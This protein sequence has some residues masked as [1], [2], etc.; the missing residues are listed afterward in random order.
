M[1]KLEVV[2]GHSEYL[3]QIKEKRGTYIIAK[4][5]DYDKKALKW[6]N[7]I[8]NAINKQNEKYE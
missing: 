4:S 7:K 6:A 2:K 5:F 1:N 3:I 8:V